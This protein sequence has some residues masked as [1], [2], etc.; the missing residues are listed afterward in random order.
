MERLDIHDSVGAFNYYLNR[1]DSC[2]MSHRQTALIKRFVEE[3]QLGRN[4]TKSVGH[5][6]L[7]ANLAS[8]FRLHD[9]FQKDF[10]LLADAELEQFYKDLRNDR[11]RQ[12]NGNAYKSGSKDE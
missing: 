12:R 10:D 1:L 9:Y 2:D 5:R 11:I 7:M 6:R 4:S 8:F 3:A